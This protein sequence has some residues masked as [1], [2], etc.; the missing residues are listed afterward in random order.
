MQST[1]RVPEQSEKK[2]NEG[3][4]YGCVFGV[5]EG[6]E[7][8][9]STHDPSEYL[10]QKEEG[11]RLYCGNTDNIKVR[12]FFTKVCQQLPK[13]GEVAVCYHNGHTDK[14]CNFHGHHWHVYLHARCHPTSDARWGK[15]LQSLGRVSPVGQK[16]YMCAAVANS[17]ALLKHILKPPRQLVWHQ[18]EEIES[19]IETFGSTN[20]TENTVD[21][22]QS[23][24]KQNHNVT[25]IKN[26]VEL[27]VKYGTIAQT[28]LRQRMLAVCDVDDP[29]SDWGNY[30]T[31]MAS[32]NFDQLVKKA[33]CIMKSTYLS[34]TIDKLFDIPLNV[35]DAKYI[36]VD[37][38]VKLFEQW[39]KHQNIDRGQFV[40]DVFDV[41]LKKR[42]KINT[43]GIQGPPNAG[44]SFVLRSLL[45]W[46]RWWGEIRL[47]AEG[48]AFAFE[49]AVDVGVI[50]I[51]EPTITPLAVEQMK[52]IMEGAETY[53]KCKNVGD[54][55]VMPTPVL[56]TY[57]SD[58][59]RFV[60]SID[61]DAIDARMIRYETKTAPFLKDWT[62]RLN[63]GIWPILY[64]YHGINLDVEGFW[65]SDIPTEEE[66]LA[67]EEE[68][69]QKEIREAEPER[70][71]R[72]QNIRA[73]LDN[74]T[75]EIQERNRERIQQYDGPFDEDTGEN[76]DDY[77]SDATELYDIIRETV[78]DNIV[79]VDE[80]SRQNLFD[81]IKCLPGA[82]YVDTNLEQRAKLDRNK[83]FWQMKA[84]DA[85]RDKWKFIENVHKTAGFTDDKI[86]EYM[87]RRNY[88]GAM[89]WPILMGL[90]TIQ[91]MIIYMQ[92]RIM[93]YIAVGVAD[94]MAD[95][96]AIGLNVARRG[97][98]KTPD[99]P[100]RAPNK[101]RL[102]MEVDATF[103]KKLKFE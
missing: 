66:Q 54:Q 62:G 45:P 99:A 41:L 29:T 88:R 55:P 5:D 53:V 90:E 84:N 28:I 91:N 98:T 2:L 81:R 12:E 25:R 71:V 74:R 15:E 86:A 34:K 63:P 97:C 8:Q 94:E 89:R 13:H 26:L 11:G 27:M 35:K 96:R 82:F 80:E 19:L 100:K 78:Y 37:Q 70:V 46:Y 52:M 95:E 14:N 83:H 85:Q 47:D 16:M 61:R 1:L 58:L 72:R 33:V 31:L 50:M 32:S 20:A 49:N 92:Q 75:N 44:K 43:L 22:E 6:V 24:L 40:R 39:C 93:K 38:S 87:E 36:P 76:Y 69:R 21:W 60:S 30:C 7:K 65:E 4:W 18:G 68:A 48:Y 79:K 23:K 10:I 56:M 3:K 9:P 64:Q 77:D 101:R 51:D 73:I 57:N 59:C 103:C 17:H 42:P 102:R 67:L